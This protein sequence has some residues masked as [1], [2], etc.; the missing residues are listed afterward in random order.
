MSL[1]AIAAADRA[2]MNADPMGPA[3][4]IVYQPEE[5]DAVTIRGVWLE[6]PNDERQPIGISVQ[7]EFSGATF[8]VSAADVPGLTRRATF[9]RPATGE[10]WVVDELPHVTGVG[11][12][13]RL[14]RAGDSSPKGLR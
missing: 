5:G 1:R 10:A 12:H 9:T 6:F 13:L 4:P 14:K 11:Y 8:D 7:S 2:R 3:E